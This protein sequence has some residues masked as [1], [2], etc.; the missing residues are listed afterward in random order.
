MVDGGRVPCQRFFDRDPCDGAM[1]VWWV[2][3]MVCGFQMRCLSWI[4][5]VLMIEIMNDDGVH[6][7]EFYVL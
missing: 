4:T 5:D 3:G 2:F 7:Y 1:A 6:G